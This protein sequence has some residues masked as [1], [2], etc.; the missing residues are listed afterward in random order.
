MT[1]T[2]S[3]PFGSSIKRREDPRLITG[4]GT[5]VDDVQAT[6]V[7][8]MAFL[9]SPHAHARIRGIRTDAA[10]QVSGVVAVYTGRDTA[11]IAGSVPC[12]WILPDM[13]MPTHPP[14]AVDTVRLTGDPVAAVL[15]ESRE[16]ASDAVSLIEVD[17]EPLPVVTN[18]IEALAEGAPKVHEDLDSNL[19]FTWKIGSGDVDAALAASDVRVSERII[20]QRLIPNAIE[21]RAVVAEY[22]VGTD[23]YVL[24]TSTQIPH[25]VRLL[26]S[27]TIGIPE[28]RL[29][30]IAPDVGG[31]FGSKL[32]LY[33]EE[34][35][36]C[37]F[38]KLSGRTVKW[39]EDR[40]EGYLATTHGRAQTH[41]IE[42]GAM[43]DGTFTALRVR[44]TAN[45]GAYLSTFAP[46][47]PTVLFGVMLSGAYRIPNIDC[48]VL[49][50]FTNTTPVDAY[51]G[52][53][54][55]EAIHLVERAVDLVADAL[56][57]DAAEIRKKNFIPATEFP[58]TSATG[59]S[60]DSGNYIVA[61][62]QA[63]QTIGYIDLLQEQARRRA[64]GGTLMGIGISSYVEICG[65][66]PSQVL[67]AVG[68]QAGGWESATVRVHAT[69][70][71]TVM[72]GA[73]SHGQGHETTFSQITADELGIPM[74]D[75]EIVHGDTD[76]VQSGIGT[77]GSRSTAVGG[78]ALHMSLTKVKDKARKIAAHQLEADESDLEY[79]EGAFRVK[80]A[81]ERAKSF[82]EIALAAFLA[83]N[84]PAG[85]EPGLD[86]TSFFDPSNFT[87][88]FGTHI[89][90]TEV[91]PDTGHVEIVRYVCVDDC[92][93]VV[94]P[95]IADGQ[96][97][98]GV[99]QGIAQALFEE[100]VY[101][102]SGQL[103]S[104]SMMDYAV[105]TAT[106]LPSFE[107]SHT[108]TPSPVNALGVKGI[109]EAGT[110][111]ASAAVVNSVVDALS[112]LGVRHLDMPLRPER[113]WRAIHNA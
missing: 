2:T 98:G 37:V 53:G 74:E 101:D 41:D 71:V 29:R 62:E 54:R 87:W 91:D 100:G 64:A 11:A 58:F 107:T 34:M 88:P 92:G 39:T 96:V 27:L 50:V 73:S 93:R 22:S 67:G 16:A 26:L 20:N 14:L 18:E 72:T 102:E 104:G 57:M 60:Y 8:Y 15:A 3:R 48:E 75:I 49:G 105:P 36:A 13:K 1:A 6:G 59:V 81:P 85:L 23:S 5:Y 43:A 51:R 78:A 35:L 70:K 86:A 90:V 46:G 113:V 32:Y 40:S 108:V 45:L 77:F 55:P 112:H 110:I 99:A 10:R 31:G 38:A 17:Y 84:Y 66:A 30:V 61:C 80:G 76:K 106:Q 89:C 9:R 4:R 25:L 52:A 28:T 103:I 56:G 42:I 44:N 19:C 12:G 33:G 109:G 7:V 79:E 68:G 94:N 24:Y 69:G 21:P 63:L 111:A 95:M 47:I 82:A 65:M 83:H 97:H